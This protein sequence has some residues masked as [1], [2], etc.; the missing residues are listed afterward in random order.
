MSRTPYAYVNEKRELVQ[1]TFVVFKD[2]E[3]RVGTIVLHKAKP[4]DDEVKRAVEKRRGP[5]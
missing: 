5:A 2:A 3:G 4:T 1:S